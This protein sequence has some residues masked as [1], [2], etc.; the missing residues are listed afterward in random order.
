MGCSGISV[1]DDTYY[2]PSGRGPS[3]WEDIKIYDSSY[4]HSQNQ[5]YWD[6]P[7]GGWGLPQAGLLKPDIAGYTDGCYT[8]SDG[9]GH[10][11]FGGTSCAT[12]HI[13]GATA[14]MVSANARAEPRHI[15]EALQIAA[16]DKGSVGKDL[17]W[18]S[19]VAKVY[20][21]A[22]R[23][24]HLAIPAQR[25]APIGSNVTVN[26][27][28]PANATYGLFYSLSL[29]TT[30]LP[31]IGDLDLAS[32]KLAQVSNLSAT[33][34]STFIGVVPNNPLLVGKT[35]YVQ[36]VCNDLAGATGQAL[37][38]LVEKVEIQ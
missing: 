25:T 8:T 29:G 34:E 10:S 36:S 27:S 33:G 6:Y 3:A 4:P 1:G 30:T 38:S 23:L 15:S 24:I 2:D 26:I 32:G 13:G 37:F 9:G 22:M 35:V 16:L 17:N 12:P 14:L 18:G 19:G 31:N 20:D 5:S 7:V 21:A 28:G 11:T